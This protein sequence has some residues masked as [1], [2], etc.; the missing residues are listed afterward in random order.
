M[1][2]QLSSLKDAFSILKMKEPKKISPEEKAD[3]I[4]RAS[5]SILGFDPLNLPIMDRVD[6]SFQKSPIA[7][8]KLGVIRKAV[9]GDWEANWDDD[10]EYKYYPWFW[11]DKPG[12]RLAAVFYVI[13]YSHSDG[14]PR[15]CLQTRVQGKFMG[16]EC[17]WLYKELMG[18]GPL[19]A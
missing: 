1:Q 16:E 7:L 17:I 12:F 19:A 5:C 11:M 13:G 15:L 4:F 3:I 14:G 18:A 8:Y 2:K 9:V 10:N 6:I